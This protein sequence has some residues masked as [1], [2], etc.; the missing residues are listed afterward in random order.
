MIGALS[1]SIGRHQAAVVGRRSGAPSSDYGPLTLLGNNLSTMLRVVENG[2]P[3]ATVIRAACRSKRVSSSLQHPRLRPAFRL[4]VSAQAAASLT[5]LASLTIPTS[6]QTA[7]ANGDTRTISL[8][9]A[10][11]K[12]SISVTFRRD[13]SYDSAALQ[14]LNYFLRDW[15]N[16]Q[17]TRMDPRLFDVI[18]ESQRGANSS[19]PVIVLS[20]YRSPTTNAML[21]AR[22][23]AVA[24]ESLHMHGKA[25]DLRLPDA[26]MHRVREVAL[27]LQRGGVGWYGRSN[28]VH[29]DVGSVRAWP[30]L[31]Y[32]HLARLFPDGKS[33]HIAA[34]GRVLPGYEEARAIVAARGDAYVPTLAQVREKGFLAR[35]FGWD[36]DDEAEARAVTSPRGRVVASAGRRAP[37]AQ[38]PSADDNTSAAFFRADAERRAGVAPVQVALAPPASEPA[39]SAP[40]AAEPRPSRRIVEDDSDAPL[41]PRRPSQAQIEALI[42]KAAPI[43]PLPPQRPESLVVVAEARAAP[44]APEASAAASPTPPVRAAA[45]MARAPGLPAVIT[46]GAPVTAGANALSVGLL[47][48]A[49]TTQPSGAET[50]RRAVP[51]KPGAARPAPVMARTIG[52]RAAQAADAVPLVA[53]R[54]DRSNFSAF[55]NGKRIIEQAPASLWGSSIAPLRAAARHDPSRLLFAPADAPAQGFSQGSLY[56]SIFGAAPNNAPAGGAVLRA[57]PSVQNFPRQAARLPASVHPAN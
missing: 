3:R 9:H 24:R 41:P 30:R 23:R 6:T 56:G 21:R 46:H 49:P 52:V 8:Y 33:V 31:S 15:R 53:A 40:A 29:L 16:D 39:R 47:A 12:D 36:E 35:L 13:G 51:R 50:I 2:A 54:L 45:A 1:Q 18:W 48:Y 7:V 20:A 32:D 10:H 55:V 26:N 44:G 22:S 42:Q 28:F 38:A 11:R 27:R 19:A 4:F 57:E 25:M 37:P 5:L 43:P 17:Q 34:D 14:Q